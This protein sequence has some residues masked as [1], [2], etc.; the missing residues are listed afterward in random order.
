MVV[1]VSQ[2]VDLSEQINAEL[3]QVLSPMFLLTL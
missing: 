1:C 2:K 3:R